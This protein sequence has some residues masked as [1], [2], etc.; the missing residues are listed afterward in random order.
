M[1]N[2]S[3][4]MNGSQCPICGRI[5]CLKQDYYKEEPQFHPRNCISV[6]QVQMQMLNSV[7]CCGYLQILFLTNRILEG[8]KRERNVHKKYLAL[9][10]AQYKLRNIP[11]ENF[12]DDLKDN[13][14]STGLLSKVIDEQLRE[15]LDNLTQWQD[16][17]SKFMGYEEIKDALGR[18]NLPFL[19]YQLYLSLSN[20]SAKVTEISSERK[21]MKN[22]ELASKRATY[23]NIEWNSTYVDIEQCPPRLCLKKTVL[24]KVLDITSFHLA[25]VKKDP[26]H[27]IMSAG[28]KAKWIKRISLP[29]V[30][31]PSECC[32]CLLSFDEEEHSRVVMSG[33][34]HSMC[35]ECIVFMAQRDCRE[36]RCPVCLAEINDFIRAK[37]IRLLKKYLNLT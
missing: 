16:K 34:Q 6:L 22:Y 5:G 33:C 15:I 2:F 27:P 19:L 32:I 23:I 13:P 25:F 28:L 14:D 4:A 20:I 37:G 26:F 11:T 29:P 35:V 21:R 1:Q 24:G 8:Q 7:D 36:Y 3:V 9:E 10:E 31:I 30:E 12:L 17:T 18:G